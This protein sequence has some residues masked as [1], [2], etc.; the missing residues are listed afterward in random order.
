[1]I[2]K[3]IN[4]IAKRANEFL[5]NKLNVEEEILVVNALTDINGK[6]SSGIENK[7]CMFLIGVEEEKVVKNNLKIS[8]NP[9]I[10]IN[11]NVM[12]AAYFPQSNYLDSLRFI[13]LVI[14]FFQNN[15]IFDFQ[16]T[17]GL[18]L[19]IPKLHVEILNMQIE[20]SMRIWGSLGPKYIPSCAYKI[21]Q[22]VFDNGDFIEDVGFIS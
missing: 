7:I 1:M 14:N 19:N 17:E 2:D 11:I 6:V 3:V 20:E 12:F 4:G 8:N 5:Q 21:R 16:N 22:I 15:P 9:A 13:S 18:P 10:Y